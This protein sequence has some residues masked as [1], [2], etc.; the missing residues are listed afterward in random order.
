MHISSNFL[1]N[2]FTGMSNRHLKLC[3]LIFNSKPAPPAGISVL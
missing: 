3:E 1:L 2:S